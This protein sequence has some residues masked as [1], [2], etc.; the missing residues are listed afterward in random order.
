MYWFCGFLFYNRSYSTGFE[1]GTFLSTFRNFFKLA[2]LALV[3]I[4]SSVKRADIFSAAA[5]ATN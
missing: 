5:E 2:L 3:S 1:P 4:Y